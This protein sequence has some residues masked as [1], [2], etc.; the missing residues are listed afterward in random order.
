LTDIGQIL[1]RAHI[2]C[3]HCGHEYYVTYGYNFTHTCKNCE[4][5]FHLEVS[6]TAV[7]TE[8]FSFFDGDEVPIDR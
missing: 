3:P 2:K 8:P 1:H 5:A 7:K 4:G 6:F